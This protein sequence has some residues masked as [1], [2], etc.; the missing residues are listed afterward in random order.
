MDCTAIRDLVP[1]YIYGDLS[2]AQ[3][4]ELKQHVDQ[5]AP[6]CAELAAL[7]QV[8][9]ALAA[10]AAP[11]TV[12]N[13]PQ[14]YQQAARHEQSRV[15]RWRRVAVAGLALAAAVLLAFVMHLEIRFADQQ[16]IVS[17]A[18][19]AP[20]VIH[21]K[22]PKPVSV[23]PPAHAPDKSRES[24][25]D[26]DPRAHLLLPQRSYFGILRVQEGAAPYLVAKGEDGSHHRYTYL[27]HGTTLHGMQFLKPDDPTQPDLSRVA[28]VYYH[29]HGPVG[30][31]ME[32]YN[33]FGDG[34]KGNEN[35]YHSD[36]RLP[37]ALVA[38][39]NQPCSALVVLWSEPPYATIGLGAGNMASYGR[40]FQHVHYYEIDE[41]VRSMS[42]PADGK[43]P[44]F[45]H[46]KDALK[47]GS[48]VQILM[49]DARQN[50][51]KPWRAGEAGKESAG[52]PDQFYSVIVVDAFSTDAVPLHLL[53]L[54][55]FE[56]LFKKLA[57]GG[58]VAIANVNPNLNLAPLI[59][60]L[61]AKHGFAWK[62]VKDKGSHEPG[63]TASDW[64][65]VAPKADNLKV[66]K[67]K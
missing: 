60:D 59:G 2:A 20:D 63:H 24:K 28:T 1:L 12:V 33:W 17:W 52:G 4:A 58:I 34:A 10:A 41:A 35:A 14:L 53:T 39:C 50:L 16:M 27:L 42:L 32:K 5:C 62:R 40:P 67:D 26:A 44:Y 65:F 49:G 36:A 23:K 51:A 6:C 25:D 13:I 64:I 31:V 45:Y 55:S 56:L 61:A 43:E 9:Q 21:T 54:E 38:T 22:P 11:A 15:R 8:R 7:E 30:L 66:V 47:R 18:G 57:P 46:V 37:A 3:A 19:A 48:N 29:R